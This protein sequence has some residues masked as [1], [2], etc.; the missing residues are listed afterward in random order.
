MAKKLCDDEDAPNMSEYFLYWKISELRM[1]THL[2]FR[3]GIS[4]GK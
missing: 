1:K 4:N 3:H 2:F